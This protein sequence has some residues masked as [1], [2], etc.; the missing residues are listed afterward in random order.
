[1]LDA[2]AGRDIGLAATGWT[3]RE[4]RQSKREASTAQTVVG[5]F[6]VPQAPLG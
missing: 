2:M 4:D 5:S 1:M 3:K 6:F